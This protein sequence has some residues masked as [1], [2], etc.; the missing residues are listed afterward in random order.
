[1]AA[2]A[3]GQLG[4][5]GDPAALVKAAAD[6]SSFVRE[7]VATALGSLGGT[8]GAHEALVALSHDDV[9]QVRDAAIASMGSPARTN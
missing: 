6:P 3:L 9:P 8:P 1:M 4:G 2:R 5:K 7:A